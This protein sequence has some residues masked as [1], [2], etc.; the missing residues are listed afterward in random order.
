MPA[1]AITK[2]IPVVPE[3]PNFSKTTAETMTVNKV[4]PLA[5]LL[6][7]VAIA[8]AATVVKKNAKSRVSAEAHR[9]HGPRNMK[10]SEE[11][12]YCDRADDHAEENG[13]DGNVTVSAFHL[14]RFAVAE[15]M[16]RDA[17]NDPV[18]TRSDLRRPARPAVAMAPTAIRRT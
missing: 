10:E 7:V 2:N 9:D 16:E 13:D 3:S 5:G 6:A 15:G 14:R 4:M 1:R 17:E 12:G 8:L 18:I 11:G